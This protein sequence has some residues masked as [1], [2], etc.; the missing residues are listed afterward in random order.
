MNIGILIGIY[1]DTDILHEFQKARDLELESCQ[2]CIW[3]T[4]LYSD[5]NAALLK[6]ASQETS[7]DISALWAGWSGPAVWDFYSGPLTLGIVPQKYR[8]IRLKEL[9]EGSDFAEK[10]G[11]SDV[12][13]H[14]GFMPENPNDPDYSAV[15]AS[16]KQLASYMKDKGQYFLF[17]T[18]QETPITLVRA[19]EDIG[20]RNLGINFDTANLIMY[21]KA[22]PVDAAGI[23]GGYVR[24]VHCKD[25]VFPVNGKNL[26]REV[27]LGEGKADIGKVIRV[28]AEKGYDGPLTIEREISGEQQVRDIISARD[29]LRKM[30]LDL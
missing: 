21:G 10:I 29:L 11:V 20:T 6:K 26:G 2:V 18:G 3:D 13:T 8:D 15:I 23:F 14:V 28:L 22:N 25:G 16:L 27:P 4:A 19:I 9:F 17:E 24:N 12:I 30:I 1:K 7:V 5:E